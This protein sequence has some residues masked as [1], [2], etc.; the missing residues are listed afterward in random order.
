MSDAR[1][2]ATLATLAALMLAAALYGPAHGSPDPAIM[3]AIM[4]GSFTAGIAGLAFSAICGA[5]LLP[6]MPDPLRMLQLL[7]ACSFANQLLVVWDLRRDI[8][9]RNLGSYVAGGVAGIAPGLWTLLHIDPHHITHG[10]GA[11]LLAYAAHLL[12]GRN[13]VFRVQSRWADAAIGFTATATGTLS[14]LPSLPVTV[15]CQARGFGKDALRATVQPFVLAMQLV[16]LP[17]LARAAPDSAVGLADLLCIPASLFGTQ[18]G[19]GCV[20]GLSNRQFTI[21]VAAL[22]IFCGLSFIL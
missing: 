13:P 10:I 8:A 7:A 20:R 2:T 9:W 12:I 19:L 6:L 1:H 14:T 4:V 18:I 5:F 22:L 21:A 15:W 3:L 11:M 16:T 17:L